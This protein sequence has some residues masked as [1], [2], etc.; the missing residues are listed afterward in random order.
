MRKYVRKSGETTHTSW[1]RCENR[2]VFSTEKAVSC[3]PKVWT[4]GEGWK[5]VMEVSQ[6]R[7]RERK[8]RRKRSWKMKRRE[9]GRRERETGGRNKRQKRRRKNREEEEREEATKE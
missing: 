6:E 7:Q 4:E 3:Q 2:K 9:K 1:Q 5:G 8:R